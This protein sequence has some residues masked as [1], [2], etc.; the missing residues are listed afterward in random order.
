MGGSA[1]LTL[2]CPV[3]PGERNETLRYML[4]SVAAHLPRA[5]VIL[6]GHCPAWVTGVEH[7]SVVQRRPD[8]SNVTR[9]LAEVCAHPATPGE[10]VL[11]NDDF[12]AMVPDTPTPLVHSGLLSDL[13]SAPGWRHGWYASALANT[14]ELLFEQGHEAPLSYDRV[15][16]PMPIRTEALGQALESAGGRPVLHRSLYGNRAGG[17]E[18]GID[19]KARAGEPLPDLPWASTA[20]SSWHRQAG[21][22]IRKM[23]SDPCRY[24]T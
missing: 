9:I 13:A 11:V 17:G 1:Q 16:Q 5:R 3:K 18:A 12:F 19:A 23:F 8:R 2:V 24:E 20:P 10:W 6:A 22:S 4:R 14:R 15:H 7:V 21:R